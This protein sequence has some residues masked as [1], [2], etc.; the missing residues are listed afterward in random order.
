M[1]RV[2]HFPKAAQSARLYDFNSV[3]PRRRQHARWSRSRAPKP[4]CRSVKSRA[5][6]TSFGSKGQ[7]FVDD[8]LRQQERCI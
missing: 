2:N 6:A 5:A 4:A 7:I 8:R 1:D 3:T